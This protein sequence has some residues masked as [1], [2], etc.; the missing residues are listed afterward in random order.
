MS[1]F[2]QKDWSALA[3]S[4]KTALS[5]A[6]KTIDR[7]LDIE[8]EQA[9]GSQQPVQTSVPNLDTDSFFDSFLAGAPSTAGNRNTKPR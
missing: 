3:Q 4:A 1:W 5:T 2:S 9:A 6:Q 7:A 8:D